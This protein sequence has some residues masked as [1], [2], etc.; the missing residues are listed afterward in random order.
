[1]TRQ[2][3]IGVAAA[4]LCAAPAHAAVPTAASGARCDG[5]PRLSVTT[6]DGFCV[7]VLAT[8][9]ALPNGDILVADMG[10]WEPNQGGVWLLKRGAIQVAMPALK[11]DNELPHDELKLIQP[12]QFYRWP[13]CYDDNRP[14][15]EYPTLGCSAY[16]APARLLPP[17]AAPLGMMFYTAGGFPALY[18]NS[19]IVGYHGYRQHG[20]R[21]VA[22]LP[23][24]AGAPLGKS[25]ELIGGWTRK[26][27]QGMGAPVD[28]KQ[29]QDGHVYIADD[30]NG[31]VLRLQYVG[32]AAR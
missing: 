1:M 32:A 4:L 18:R 3:R 22:L 24:K 10:G 13:Y 23:D 31:M 9:L 14:S 2:G 29:G 25:V 27:K 6:P 7:A 28:V 12:G 19:L 17:H 8:G 15:P 16:R 26:G 11:N 5:L 20:H 21:L 30:R